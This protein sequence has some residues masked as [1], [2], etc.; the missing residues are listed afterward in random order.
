MKIVHGHD[1]PVYQ[2]GDDSLLSEVFHPAH[3]GIGLPFSIARAMLMPG[4]AT[5]HH[6]LL[7]SSEVYVFLSG[8]GELHCDG[9]EALVRAGDFALIPAGSTQWVQSTGEEPLVFLCIVTPP[10]NQSDEVLD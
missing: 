2:A 8:E 5:R 7:T 4:G 9:E 10:W 6:R 3:T 1:A